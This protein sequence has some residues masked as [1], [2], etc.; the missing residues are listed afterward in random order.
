MFTGDGKMTSYLNCCGIS[1]HIQLHPKSAVLFPKKSKGGQHSH[2]FSCKQ[3]SLESWTN[4]G[5]DHES[6]RKGAG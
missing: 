3:G 1:G 6:G 5:L 4:H 2:Y